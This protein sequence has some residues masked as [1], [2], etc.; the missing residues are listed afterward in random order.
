MIAQ[1]ITYSI[2]VGSWIDSGRFLRLKLA[3]GSGGNR[4]RRL[5]L[6]R[7]VR[8][9]RGWI[10]LQRRLLDDCTSRRDVRLVGL[11]KYVPG[12]CLLP[13]TVCV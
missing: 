9:D 4:V 7:F 5:R 10:W 2:I 1:L 6:G 13:A 11:L 8:L 3:T 12:S